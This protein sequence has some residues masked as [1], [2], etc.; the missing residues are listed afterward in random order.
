MV[1]C[2]PPKKPVPTSDA[3]GSTCTENFEVGAAW[4]A[5]SAP[6]HP[7]KPLSMTYTLPKSCSARAFATSFADPLPLSMRMTCWP[8]ETPLRAP[9]KTA[10][11][12]ASVRRGARSFPRRSRGVAGGSTGT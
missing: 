4:V 9:T 1:F 6:F 3:G 12:R 11:T 7:L 5:K 10:V 8:R 2:E